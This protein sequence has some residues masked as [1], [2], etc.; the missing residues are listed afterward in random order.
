MTIYTGIADDNGN[1]TIDISSPLTS[2]EI[3]QVTAQKDGQSKSI[4]IQA[5]SEPYNSGGALN[6]EFI[7]RGPITCPSGSSAFRAYE[8]DL[9]S[10][11][12]VLT[13]LSDECEFDFS[14]AFR[15]WKAHTINLPAT[16]KHLWSYCFYNWGNLTSFTC[17]RDLES[18]GDAVFFNA[19]NLT[20]I[21]FN[22][23]LLTVGENITS[24]T[25]IKNLTFPDSVKTF[26]N[27]CYQSNIVETVSIGSQ[28]EKIGYLAFAHTPNLREVVINATTPPDIRS[29]DG[30]VALFD[31]SNPQAV[32][33]VPAAAV[34]T[35]KA[36][37]SWRNYAN[38]I[39]AI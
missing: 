6:K 28:V 39:T 2:G 9:Y 16:Q 37:S 12:D 38:N 30:F 5:P 13:I 8:G 33:K 19:S 23:G 7:I 15:D 11:M 27:I 18:F 22:E 32:I 26:S 20:E 29:S 1:F 4:N 36:D 10:Q 31:N 34:E 24:G 25:G 14:T 3:V 35:Y 17:P 21:I